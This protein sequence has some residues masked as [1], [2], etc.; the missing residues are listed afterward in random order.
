MAYTT[1]PH[2]YVMCLNLSVN[3]VSSNLDSGTHEIFSNAFPRPPQS[4]L[5]LQAANLNYNV[6]IL[7]TSL[8]KAR[9]C[10]QMLEVLAI[11]HTGNKCYRFHKY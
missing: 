3:V 6:S 1:T 9:P 8:S 10:T 2:L 7:A 11:A 5:C 4:E